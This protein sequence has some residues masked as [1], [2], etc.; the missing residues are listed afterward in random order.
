MD[1][2]KGKK[3]RDG[4]VALGRTSFIQ[5]V[6]AVLGGI[7]VVI[8]LSIPKDPVEHIISNREVLKLLLFLIGGFP[9]FLVSP[10]GLIT[11]IVS[12]VRM[13]SGGNKSKIWL[14]IAGIAGSVSGFVIA[15]AFIASLR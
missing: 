9:A 2:I 6:L 12:F 15:A 1:G 4:A 8:S 10:A 3:T 11:G 14:P 13:K 7:T 5:A